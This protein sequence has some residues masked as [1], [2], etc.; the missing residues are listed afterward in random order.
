MVIRQSVENE[1]DNSLD[2]HDLG[3]QDLRIQVEVLNWRLGRVEPQDQPFD[4]LS[5]DGD[6]NGPVYDDI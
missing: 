3:T 6:Y 4:E 5:Y 1:G 2:P